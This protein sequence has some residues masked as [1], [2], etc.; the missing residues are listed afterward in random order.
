M[1]P[2]QVTWLHDPVVAA[3]DVRANADRGFR[4]VS[5][6]E[7]P[8]KLGLPSI[9]SHHWDPFLAACEET[10]TVVNLHVG[11]SSQL[12]IPSTDS[13]PAV[14]SALFPVNS[15][16]ACTDWLYSYIPGQFPDVRIVFSEGGI[17]WVPMMRDRIRYVDLHFV[18]SEGCR[19]G[20]EADVDD[21]LDAM[22]RNF[23]FA[24]YYDP[25]AL[26]LRDDI[27]VDHILLEADYPHPDSVWPDCQSVFQEVF[28][29]VPESE[30]RQL[31]YEN[32]CRLYRHPRP[33][34]DFLDRFQREPEQTLE[35]REE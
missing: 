26:K 11:S 12:I 8:E 28:V 5:F 25:S 22:D 18:A 30:R 1:I 6:S 13:A 20:L 29:G 14:G 35:L 21:L 27:G 33:T 17:G 3:R 7:N 10:Q 31:L 34:A 23:F 32:A 15:L 16:M 2:C 19:D 9:H 4:A 24:S